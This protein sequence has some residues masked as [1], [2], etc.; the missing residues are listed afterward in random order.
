MSNQNDLKEL[1]GEVISY[2]GGVEQL[3]ADGQFA[4]PYPDRWPWLVL[5]QN[6]NAACQ[7][8]KSSD[9]KRTF[10]QKAV[11]LC[12]D[13]IMAMQADQKKPMQQRKV[14]DWGDFLTLEGTVAGTVRICMNDKG[15][16][17]IYTPEEE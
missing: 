13:A 12:M 11:P 14:K 15:G 8:D 4:H 17:T 10:D 2:D 1:F 6:V 7:E 5:S 16:M 3:V 9:D